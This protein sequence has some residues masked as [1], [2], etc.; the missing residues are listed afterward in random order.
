M[1]PLQRL[2]RSRMAE[3]EIT[4]R[5]VAQ[6]GDL[7]WSTVS[8]LA[9]KTEHRSVPRRGT[10]EKLAKG[11]DLPVDMVASAA[12]ESA[13][14]N[15]QEVPTTLE[16]SEDVRIVVASMSKMSP[17]DRAKLRRL[18]QAFRDEVDAEQAQQ[19]NELGG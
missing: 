7:P 4:F 12:A 13:G 14:L 1:N 5:E 18:A 10:L 15:L 6:R 16:A 17:A 11:L 19:P 2:I 9:N 3:L 8:A